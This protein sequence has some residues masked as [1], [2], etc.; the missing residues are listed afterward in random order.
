MEPA[1]E[2]IDPAE[3][4]R[5]RLLEAD[6]ARCRCRCC[7]CC[8]CCCCCRCRRCRCRRRCAFAAAVASPLLLA[9]SPLLALPLF[10]MRVT[11]TVSSCWGLTH[12]SVRPSTPTTCAPPYSIP[13][14]T[15]PA[16]V[17]P[18][19]GTGGPLSSERPGL[20]IRNRNPRV[21]ALQRG[22]PLCLSSAVT[23]PAPGSSPCS[24]PFTPFTAS[25]HRQVPP[26]P[27]S[28]IYFSQ[29]VPMLSVLPSLPPSRPLR[30]RSSS[31]CG[32]ST[33]PCAA[34]RRRCAACP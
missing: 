32:R 30:S 5:R 2:D 17:E 16:R 27:L 8:C 29:V 22:Q 28:F 21:G 9:L 15:V 13:Y 23:A 25:P 33:A 6:E 20:A 24:A 1:R 26:Y 7:C 19:G 18:A 4:R 12:A 14:G 3:L 10:A 34:R 11:V 31:A